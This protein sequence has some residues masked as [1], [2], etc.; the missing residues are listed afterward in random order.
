MI[1]TI[2]SIGVFSTLAMTA[3]SYALSYF[4]SNKF[5]EPQLLN[6]LLDRITS[7]EKRFYNEHIVGWSIH[8]LIGILFVIVYFLLKYFQILPQGILYDSLFG[9]CAGIIGVL[10][11]SI[12]FSLHPNPPK[13]NRALYYLQLIPAHII[14]G[15]CCGILFNTLA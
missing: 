12:T 3:F 11:W 6:I 9:F 5:E 7:A 13:I 1:S 15:I 2:F 10:F 8:C 4:T 14:F